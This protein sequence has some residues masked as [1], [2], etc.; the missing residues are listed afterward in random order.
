VGLW[1]QSCNCEV[2]LVQEAQVK[3]KHFHLLSEQILTRFATAHSGFRSHPKL[4]RGKHC[5]NSRTQQP[6]RV[7]TPA[8]C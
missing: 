2:R 1:L 5:K 3:G 7:I 4:S 6:G 8:D